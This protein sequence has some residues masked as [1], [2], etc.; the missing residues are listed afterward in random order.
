MCTPDSPGAPAPRSA[1]SEPSATFFGLLI[2]PPLQSLPITYRRSTY[3]ALHLK[4]VLRWIAN[5]ICMFSQQG[6]PIEDYQYLLYCSVYLRA[7][8]CM[9]TCVY[10]CNKCKDLL[11]NKHHQNPT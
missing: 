7:K 8:V 5:S 11:S 3:I 1:C 4:V 2:S 6:Q 9:W 10:V